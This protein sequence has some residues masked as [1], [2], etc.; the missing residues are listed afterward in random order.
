MCQEKARNRTVLETAAM[1]VV[2]KTRLGEFI[3]EDD[4]DCSGEDDDDGGGGEGA[5]E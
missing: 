1:A 3:A 4:D 5:R 2:A